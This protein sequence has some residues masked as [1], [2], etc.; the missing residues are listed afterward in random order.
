MNKQPIDLERLLDITCAMIGLVVLTPVWAAVALVILI[1]EGRPVFF[2]Q[3]RIGRHGRQFVIWKFR[4]MVNG[5]SGH[6]ITA[7]GDCRVTRVGAWL[8]K[9]KL[10]ELPQIFNVLRGDMSLIGPRP[11]VPQYVEMTS[12]I[13][14]EVLQF[15]PGI[16]DLATLIHR[17]EEHI[18]GTARD[19]QDLYR[20]QILPAKLRLNLAYQH[21]RSFS[22]DARL[23]FLTI[24]YSLCPDQ[25]RRDSVTKILGIATVIH[26]AD[27]LHPLSCSLNR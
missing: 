19:P 13:W 11:E 25:F 18:L 3:T 8:R 21:A 12:P 1:S 26:D 16:T 6:G 9:F 27:Y 20:N 5:L 10:D 2:R 17:D 23:I 15:R 4:T 14:Q 24:F 7:A 22:R